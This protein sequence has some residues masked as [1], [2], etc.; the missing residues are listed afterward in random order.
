MTIFYFNNIPLCVSKIETVHA[1]TET[2]LLVTGVQCVN[3]ILTKGNHIFHKYFRF[4]ERSRINPLEWFA[5]RFLLKIRVKMIKILLE[6]IKNN[7]YQ[8]VIVPARIRERISSGNH[9]SKGIRNKKDKN[10]ISE[11]E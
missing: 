4:H 6:Q 8:K 5:L 11:K 10:N 9:W 3:R 2:C 7:Y 1:N